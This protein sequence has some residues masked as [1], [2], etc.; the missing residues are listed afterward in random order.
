MPRTVQDGGDTGEVITGVG[1]QMPP[2]VE[3]KR[4]G[5]EEGGGPAAKGDPRDGKARTT[6]HK[7][8]DDRFASDGAEV[9]PQPGEEGLDQD[10]IRPQKGL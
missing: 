7:E 6:K 3:R 4:F 5:L 1:D 8:V 2:D 10:Q 9:D